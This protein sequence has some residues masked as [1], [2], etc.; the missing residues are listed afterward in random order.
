MVRKL[1]GYPQTNMANIDVFITFLFHK[2]G[3]NGF[4]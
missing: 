1:K 4:H 3:F 2:L